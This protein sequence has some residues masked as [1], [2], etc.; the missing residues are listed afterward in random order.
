MDVSLKKTGLMP[1][2]PVKTRGRSPAPVP[3]VSLNLPES[4]RARSRTPANMSEEEIQ[5]K[6]ERI[7]R[8]EEEKKLHDKMMRRGKSPFADKDKS[9][10]PFPG[11]LK[12]VDV[13]KSKSPAPPQRA[14]KKEKVK[15][16]HVP[17]VLHQT[18]L[19]PHFK[20]KPEGLQLY[21][22]DEGEVEF[23]VDGNPFP[24]VTIMK[25]T[26]AL[27]SGVH[28]AITEDKVTGLCNFTIKKAKTDDEGKYVAK[29]KAGSKE[30]SC[31]FSVFVKVEGGI[32]LR[33]SLKTTSK[34][35]TSSTV[36]ETSSST[37]IESSSSSSS[38]VNQKK[39][40]KVSVA[41]K[42]SSETV[43]ETTNMSKAD[44]LEELEKKKKSMKKDSDSGATLKFQLK[45]TKRPDKGPKD[46]WEVELQPIN[47]HEDDGK[48]K[49]SCVFWKPS[50]QGRWY[51]D[52]EELFIGFKYRMG[53]D[54]KNH[55]L[56]ISKLNGDDTGHYECIANNV[57]T[58]ADIYVE[59]AAPKYLF[60]KE[61]NKDYHAFKK[62]TVIMECFVND[63]ESPHEWHKDK[64]KIDVE[65]TT[66]EADHE[67]SS[68]VEAYGNPRMKVI[69]E[70]TRLYIK[71]E[72]LQEG[73]QGRYDCILE[74][75][76]VTFCHLY[77]DEP[78][79][80]FIKRLENCE[81]T[82]KD[83]MVLE[84]DMEDADADVSWYRNDAII[85]PNIDK[86]W[87][88]EIDGTF[89][90]LI[91]KS[92][93]MTHKGMFRAQ[94]GGLSSSGRVVVNRCFEIVKPLVDIEGLEESEIKM[95]LLLSRDDRGS[96]KWFKN[97]EQIFSE[98]GREFDDLRF[99][100]EQDGCKYVLTIKNI[101]IAD[102]GLYEATIENL[103][104]SCQFTVSICE[105]APRIDTSQIP[106]EI[107]VDAGDPIDLA[108]PC[109]AVPPPKVKLAID[110]ED[111][112]KWKMRMGKIG[113]PRPAADQEKVTL[114]V[115]KAARGHS[116]KYEVEISNSRGTVKV[117][118]KITVVDKPTAPRGPL[119]LTDVF[120]DHST[121][122]WKPPEDDGGSPIT[123][124]VIEKMDMTRGTW[125]QMH[126]LHGDY[127]K[128]QK[129][130]TTKGKEYKFRVCAVNRMGKGPWLETDG[131]SLA[132][133]P[134]DAPSAPG[135][136]TIADWDHDHVDLE[137]KAPLKDGGAP[138]TSYIVEK[139]WKKDPQGENW[140]AVTTSKN[141]NCRVDKVTE[142]KDYEFRVRA[143][144]AE[145]PGE[146]SESSA[147][148]KIKHRFVAPKIE[149][150]SMKPIKVKAG[151]K[152][153]IK[154]PVK[155]R[156]PP[157]VVWTKAGVVLKP[158]KKKR[159]PTKE[160]EAEMVRLKGI[161]KKK[162]TRKWRRR[163][164]KRRQRRKRR[165]WSRPWWSLRSRRLRK[166]IRTRQKRSI[167]TRQ[168]RSTRRR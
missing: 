103:K 63:E 32:D 66:R 42:G 45:K 70:F 35:E 14:P 24:K 125:V 57:S 116:G 71:I 53:M 26:R 142:G 15:K 166:R 84:V 64:N 29:I 72:K 106:K 132:K 109:I 82:E 46:K 93:Q 168:V 20:Q 17:L 119:N 95:E 155:G 138:I 124:Y 91:C 162:E 27:T 114:K 107:K 104:S 41:G 161:P 51:K 22:G 49:L 118:I 36:I 19:A 117:P 13:Q 12:H 129:I 8:M 111:E 50:V 140:V 89:R 99:S 88:E 136:P 43:T 4:D 40:S 37:V 76:Q 62:K 158:L 141:T 52:K 23:V 145:G 101:R 38:T 154:V 137:W 2:Q 165:R 130:Q 3:V 156:P 56:N 94:C 122:N 143:V 30:D 47:A 92:V 39:S 73:D 144:N 135:K 34:K 6:R 67:W 151:Q 75:G 123:G 86:E 1:D 167:Q 33:E 163:S 79:Y 131:T 115:V 102:S 134:Y 146:P 25:G 55:H 18:P 128:N 113:P 164:W 159:K 147:P 11:Q 100:C 157:E 127:H 61:L 69:H 87:E 152:M 10:S 110:G 126:D 105:K 44:K 48:L 108:I 80:K 149:L 85:D 60:T 112:D 74:G 7:M 9:K 68:V 133:N 139:W 58:G 28:Y 31:A 153:T 59:P 81:V 83:R 90:R 21:E 54:A 16:I 97:G 5:K 148:L 121:V 65:E 120:A 78:Q 96:V 150:R 160:E 98:E 77:V